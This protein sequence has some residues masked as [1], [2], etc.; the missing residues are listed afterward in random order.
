MWK[1]KLD[2]TITWLN[3]HTQDATRLGKP[4]LVEEFGKAVAAAKIYSGQ[5]PHSPEKCGSHSLACLHVML[6]LQGR[7][8]R[9]WS[10]LQARCQ[11][12][13]RDPCTLDGQIFEA[14]SR[15]VNGACLA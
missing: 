3:A 12:G 6:L 13:G 1:E 11:N 7:A 9:Q 5:L 8:P 15:L 4:M 2:Y 10:L 14:H